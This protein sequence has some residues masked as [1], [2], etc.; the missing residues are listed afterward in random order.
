M[1]MYIADPQ[2]AQDRA[3][4]IAAYHSARQHHDTAADAL[5]CIAGAL[6]GLSV[7]HLSDNGRVP[8]NILII[9]GEVAQWWML[10]SKGMPL[11]EDLL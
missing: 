1:A 11:P 4:V 2:Y 8:Y 10:A 7:Q 3:E 5:S 6:V 9:M